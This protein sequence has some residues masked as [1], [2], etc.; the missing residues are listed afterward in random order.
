MLETFPLLLQEPVLRLTCDYFTRR[1]LRPDDSP[2]AAEI[3]DVLTENL[4]PLFV[5]DAVIEEHV[6]FERQCGVAREARTTRGE[7]RL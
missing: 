4:P 7:L 3:V 2:E 1:P 6:P 5:A